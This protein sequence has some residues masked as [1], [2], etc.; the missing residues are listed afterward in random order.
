MKI[1]LVE[2]EVKVRIH[3][4]RILSKMGL[5]NVLEADN[6]KEAL[7]FLEKEKIDLIISDIKM[8]VMDGI[9][10]L[11]KAKETKSKE[12]VFI[13]LSAYDSFQNAQKAISYG[14]FSY[15]LKPIK[16]EELIHTITLAKVQIDNERFDKENSQLFKEQYHE[17]LK[18]LKRNFLSSI[19]VNP[20][21]ESHY[22]TTQMKKLKFEFHRKNYIV[23]LAIL[24]KRNDQSAMK[25]SQE[26]SLQ[27]QKLNEIFFDSFSSWE[28]EINVFDYKQGSGFLMNFNSNIPM[29]DLDELYSKFIKFKR[30]IDS[31]L[32][33][34]ITIAIGSIVN[35][36]SSLNRSYT[37]ALNAMAQK[38]VNADGV[39]Y[40]NVHGSENDHPV[41]LDFE[42]ERT[43]LRCFEKEEKEAA[44]SVIKKL[45]AEVIESTYINVE[46]LQNLNYQLLIL[47]FKITRQ[48]KLDPEELLGDEYIL[49][50]EVNNQTSVDAMILWFENIIIKCFHSLKDLL[51]TSSTS[52]IYKAKDF[53]DSNF[54]NDISLEKVASQIYMSPE[55][56]SREFKK[57]VGDTYINYVTNLRMSKAK[58][59]L[60]TS[61]IQI[62]KISNM[63][64]FRNTKYF[65]KIFKSSTGNTPSKYRLLYGQP[66]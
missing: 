14:A 44:L 48:I 45:Y 54:A 53:I 39:Y 2:D 33:I 17:N 24:E 19:I 37:A 8:P 56:F 42:T 32:N 55:H 51:L 11:G 4:K 52:S 28:L 46:K 1:L 16:D 7:N 13:I 12:S 9:T 20:I 15:L 21:S 41:I 3:V 36:V 25:K 38:L 60:T 30:V 31:K 66:D 49:Y 35:S 18:V 47:I 26:I 64:G 65:S 50:T 10:L 5:K 27:Y 43:L 58:H 6:G 23:I 61:N 29:E 63:V 22:I 40:Q 62:S 57:T 34:P 59:Y